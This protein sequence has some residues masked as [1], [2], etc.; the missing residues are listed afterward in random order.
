MSVLVLPLGLWGAGRADDLENAEDDAEREQIESDLAPLLALAE[1]GENLSDWEY[2][3]VLVRDSYFTDY[4][5]QL[6]DDLGLINGDAVWPVCHIDWEAAAR[7]GSRRVPP[8]GA[9]RACA[10]SAPRQEDGPMKITTAWGWDPKYPDE[11]PTLV[12]AFDEYTAESWNGVPEFYTDEVA[13]YRASVEDRIEV[14]EI[15]VQ[16]SGQS[17]WNAFDPPVVNGVA[18]V[19]D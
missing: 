7:A 9:R 2:G 14:R 18:E 11:A 6:A 5:E 12:A 15:V 8:A 19:M 3:V 17:I 1:E 16:V 4:A 13:K 10:A